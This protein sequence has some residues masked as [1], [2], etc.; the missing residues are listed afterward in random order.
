MFEQMRQDEEND[1]IEAT[2]KATPIDYA[3]SRQGISPQIV[4]YHVRRGNLKMHKCDCGR[5]VIDVKEADEFFKN[6]SRNRNKE[7]SVRSDESNDNV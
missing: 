5:N 2:N 7:S 4:Y 6:Q 1:R 3:K